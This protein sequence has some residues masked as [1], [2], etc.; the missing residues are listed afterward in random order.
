[1]AFVAKVG[2]RLP[3]VG[4]GPGA[5]CFDICAAMTKIAA[6]AASAKMIH[7]TNNARMRRFLLLRELAKTSPYT[8]KSFY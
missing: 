8:H 3:G 2:N 6:T 4:V 1:V 7:V 5:G